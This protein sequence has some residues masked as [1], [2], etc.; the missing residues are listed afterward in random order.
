MK[1]ATAATFR[2][3][4]PTRP[5]LR[6]YLQAIHRE[7]LT[8]NYHSDFGPFLLAILDKEHNFLNINQEKTAKTLASFTDTIEFTGNLHT[9]RYKGHT[10]SP[11]KI[12]AINRLLEKRFAQDLHLYCS[13]ISKERKW[14]PGTAAALEIFA[15]MCG[16]TLETDLPHGSDQ[17]PDITTDALKKAEYRQRKKMDET[18]Q[19]FVPGFSAGQPG[20]SSVS[21]F[22]FGGSVAVC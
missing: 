20:A 1:A 14:R 13:R 18:L 6:K 21:L 5:Y 16:L 2:V 9:M 15:Q 3:K 8:L 17:K 7:E 19:T 12:L 11:D 10:I 4:V 22:S